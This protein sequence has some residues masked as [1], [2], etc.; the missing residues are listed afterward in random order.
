MSL[1]TANVYYFDIFAYPNALYKSLI[2]I[3]YLEIIGK[4]WI[5]IVLKRKSLRLN[6]IVTFLLN[7]YLAGKNSFFKDFIGF[8]DYQNSCFVVKRALKF[9]NKSYHYFTGNKEK[10]KKH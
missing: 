8:N 3:Y 5:T 1:N 9:F 2:I 7:I 4:S 6:L 10:V